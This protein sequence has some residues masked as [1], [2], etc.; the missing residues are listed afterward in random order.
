MKEVEVNTHNL[1]SAIY[2]AAEDEALWP[3]QTTG[4]LAMDDSHLADTDRAHSI[5]ETSLKV[6]LDRA[7][8]MNHRLETM[9][10]KA[11]AAQQLLDNLPQA[12]FTVDKDAN[13]IAHNRQSKQL[14]A[15]NTLI[16][17]DAGKLVSDSDGNTTRIRTVIDAALS[18]DQRDSKSCVIKLESAREKNILFVV[19]LSLDESYV[20]DNHLCNVFVVESNGQ[21]LV[22]S[23]LLRDIYQL[24]PAEI[25]LSQ[26][27]AG[28]HS[29]TEIAKQ[30]GIRPNTA[31][32]HLKSIF[33]K[34]GSHRQ[35]ELVSL[36]LSMS[37]ALDI[38]E[39]KSAA[40][41]D[42]KES[43]G[44]QQSMFRSEIALQDG[45]R[46][47]YLEL[48]D[49]L[50]LP[51]IYQHDIV[52]WD[53]WTLVDKEVFTSL[54]IRFIVPFRPGFRGSDF[55][56]RVSLGDWAND[57]KV[58]LETLGIEQFY[59]WGFSSGGAYALAIAHSL[60]QRCLGLALV[61]SIAPIE[62][63]SDFHGAKP[64]ITPLIMGFAKYSSGLY[65]NFFK[66]VLKTATKNS[67]RYI[68]NYISQWSD[69]DRELL[70]RPKI[71]HSIDSCFVDTVTSDSSGLASESVVITKPWNF[72]LEDITTP[73]VI[74]QG[75]DDR[76]VST[77]LANKLLE[78]PVHKHYLVDNCGHL[79]I[80]DHWQA[81]LLSLLASSEDT[82]EQSPE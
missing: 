26:L 78:I 52:A 22:S 10:Q 67:Q 60:S 62:K 49:P 71:I 16:R 17:I 70:D 47:F 48:G 81:I 76:A 12:I 79:H 45:R 28:G 4:A 56:E 5:D 40:T 61:S 74:W 55:H 63:M 33:S 73:T 13:L 31:R 69:Y 44:L 36:I 59:L 7:V 54:G 27:L 41:Q 14:M 58:L 38:P 46:L 42:D 24:T 6:H 51:I 9:T 25:R 2:E 53:W 64:S 77:T 23:S 65:R 37:P 34:T 18:R 72:V 30:L 66:A 39:R 15:E 80:I 20:Q 19:A 57:T 50:G 32:N 3:S 75:Q 21:L 43:V 1:I 68:S 82:A 29:L 35:S 8:K 11:G